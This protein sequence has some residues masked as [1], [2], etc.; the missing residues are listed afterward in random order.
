MWTYPQPFDI[1]VIG[2]GHAGAEAAH[3]AASMGASTLLLTLNLDAIGKMSCNPAIGGTAKGHIVREI[4]ALGGIMGKIADRSAIQW[5]MLNR[6]K[7]PAV[8]AP[9]AQCDRWAYQQAMKWHL[10]QT[11][12]LTIQQGQVLSLESEGGA[13]SGVTTQEGVHYRCR[14]VI[15]SSGTFMR[16]LCHIGEAR[17]Q[18]GRMGEKPSNALSEALIERGHSL[19]RLKTGT[20]PRLDGRTLDT[21]QMEEQPSE[22]GVAF[23]FDGPEPSLENLSCHIAYTTPE[24]H[25]LIAENIHRSPIYSGAIESAGPRYCP[26]IE[27]KVHRFPGRERHQ[28]F[29]EPEGLRTH[30][31]YLNGLS[32]SLPFE[33][34]ERVLKEIPGLEKAVIMRPGYAIEYDYLT[35]GQIDMTLQSRSLP[36]LYFAGQINGTTGY[37]E[38]AAQGL[39]AGINAALKMRG[40]EP[41]LLGREEAYIGVMIDDLLVMKLEEPYRMFTS[42][43]ERRLLLRQ[44][45]ADIRLRE[46]GIHLGLIGGERAT[47]HRHKVA[48]IEGALRALHQY[49]E[50]GETLYHLLKRPGGE[51]AS[52]SR[53]HPEALPPLPPSWG[54]L[55]ERDVKFS[56][57]I[58]REKKEAQKL[59]HIDSYQIPDDFDYVGMLGLRNEAREQLLSHRPHTLGQASRLSGVSPADISLLM[60]RLRTP[61]GV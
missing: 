27:D 17:S 21:R 51:Y 58:E 43:A 3:A 26:S 59:Q 19:G 40:G 48:S 54:E 24:A 2:G 53:R 55:I 7:G 5:R 52:L 23:S 41:F 38:A 14:S 25:A 30:E 15:L 13:I 20:P 44:D 45:N 4:D 10:E 31:V 57:Y 9:R 49:R 61:Q 36:G 37:E 34:Q 29:I 6:S 32:S 50:G 60:V 35:S 46:Y 18:G 1:I 12:N 56:G 47:Q 33:I 8:H 42:R 11:E 22:G 39:M 28:L 16:G